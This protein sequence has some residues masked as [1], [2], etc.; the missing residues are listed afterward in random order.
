LMSARR[1]LAGADSLPARS[2]E[3]GIAAQNAFIPVATATVATSTT[4]AKAR[5]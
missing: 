1:V 5:Q 3:W 2:S 4:A